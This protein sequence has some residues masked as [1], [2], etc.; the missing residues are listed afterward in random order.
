MAIEI[1]AP[2]FPESVA[3]GTVATWHKQPGDAVKRDDLIVDIETDKVVL[4]VLAE[5]DG[6]LGAI[7]AEEGATVLSNQ[8]LGSIEAGGVAAAPAAATV[9]AAAQAPAAQAPGAQAPVAQ[10]GT[11]APAGNPTEPIPATEHPTLPIP[12]AYGAQAAQN[13]AANQNPYGAPAPQGRHGAP[14]P[15][16]AP[17]A[18]QNPTERIPGVQQENAGP[19]TTPQAAAQPGQPAHQANGH[20]GPGYPASNVYPHALAPAVTA[21]PCCVRSPRA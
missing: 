15:Y 10:S 6:V 1:K 7:V 9:P 17:A 4:E 3:D 16:G 12:S 8:V 13:P 5:A 18:T 2:T 11:G 20:A 21:A 14:A 19:G